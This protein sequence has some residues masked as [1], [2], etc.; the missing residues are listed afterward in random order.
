MTADQAYPTLL[1]F[2]FGFS[3]LTFIASFFYTTPYGRFKKA[4][5]K[6]QLPSLAGWLLMEFPCL[7]ACLLTFFLSGGNTGALV[8][9][10]FLCIWQSH[11]VYRAIIFPLRMRDSGKQMPLAIASIY[12]TQVGLAVQTLL[13]V[14]PLWR[15]ALRSTSTQTLFCAIYANPAKAAIKSHKVV[16]IAGSRYP[17]TLARS[18]SGSAYVLPL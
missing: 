6:F 1:W 10:V 14:L 2:L 3:G 8:P 7:V 5:E 4:D 13:S 11:Y 12:S 18:S 16:Y 15:S 17:I 9:L